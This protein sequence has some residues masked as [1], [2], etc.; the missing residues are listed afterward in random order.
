MSTMESTPL[1]GCHDQKFRW[2]NKPKGDIFLSFE[3]RGHSDASVVLNDNNEVLDTRGVTNGQGVPAFFIRYANYQNTRTLI[4]QRD[5]GVI[6]EVKHKPLLSPNKFITLWLNIS[7]NIMSLGKGTPCAGNCLLSFAIPSIDTSILTRIGF[8]TWKEAIYLRNVRIQKP[9][10]SNSSLRCIVPAD[11]NTVD[12]KSCF[13]KTILI[14]ESTFSASE[15]LISSSSN[16]VTVNDDILVIDSSV[17]LDVFQS[18]YSSLEKHE[19]PSKQECELMKCNWSSPQNQQFNYLTSSDDVFP[20]FNFKINGYLIA[21]KEILLSLEYFTALCSFSDVS[22]DGFDFPQMEQLPRRKLITGI[23]VKNI[24]AEVLRVKNNLLSELN[25]CSLDEVILMCEVFSMIGLREAMKSVENYF[26]QFLDVIYNSTDEVT[27]II[28]I[29]DTC[30]S[31]DLSTLHESVVN[32]VSESRVSRL[33]T[34]SVMVAIPKEIVVEVV[35]NIFQRGDGNSC[36]PLSVMTSE[37]DEFV[38]INNLH[39]NCSSPHS[40]WAHELSRCSYSKALTCEEV[41]SSETSCSQKQ[42]DEDASC[43]PANAIFTNLAKANNVSNIVRRGLIAVRTSSNK[44]PL[45]FGWRLFNRNPIIT[46]TSSP[47][48]NNPLPFIIFQFKTQL[49]R[50]THYSIQQSKGPDFISSW[51]LKGFSNDKWIDLDHRDCCGA[52]LQKDKEL[53]FR[54]PSTT[55]TF[56]EFQL[57]S[58]DNREVSLQRVEIYG[59]VVPVAVP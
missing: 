12:W 30:I 46:F 45:S 19:Q 2:F 9:F 32:R 49:V 51:D 50:P 41:M 56:S 15:L 52:F 23:I 10:K 57:I 44:N 42:T 17:P 7:N 39:E 6:E 38:R 33:F 5:V 21:H 43:C 48:T 35:K 4:T 25:N 11:V 14:K 27:N 24:Y 47:A 36:V 58:L 54:L 3:V 16:A 18:W 55:D 22:W 1:E 53:V 59:T 34:A 20:H 40:F 8:T 26:I 13:K 31:Y 37:V 29:C 28:K